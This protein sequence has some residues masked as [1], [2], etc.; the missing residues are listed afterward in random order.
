VQNLEGGTRVYQ[1]LPETEKSCEHLKAARPWFCFPL[2]M[3][4]VLDFYFAT[5]RRLMGGVGLSEDPSGPFL[6]NT[7]GSALLK[8]RMT[9][10]F[11][12]FLYDSTGC[13]TSLRDYRLGFSAAIMESELPMSTIRFVVQQLRHT[14]ATA[15][16]YY[17]Q[18]V[19]S[20]PA[21]RPLDV[22]G[23]LLPV[24]LSEKIV[25]QN[26]LQVLE[27][28]IEHHRDVIDK[29][30]ETLA[31]EELRYRENVHARLP[32]KLLEL[33]EVVDDALLTSHPRSLSLLS[34][35]PP[36]DTRPVDAPLV[37]PQLPSPEL[38]LSPVVAPLKQ[39][40]TLS[41]SGEDDE[42]Q[43]LEHTTLELL[44]NPLFGGGCMVV[45]CGGNGNCGPLVVA[46][47]LSLVCSQDITAE[48]VREAVALALGEPS[49][50]GRY[51]EDR[52]DRCSCWAV[53]GQDHRPAI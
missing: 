8:D 46:A 28:A 32:E 7:E 33:P 21:P 53:S 25:G 37:T 14:Y 34:P 30:I 3:T 36:L 40:V 51:W 44:Q 50:P 43:R 52:G 4:P 29:C 22:T 26:L 49:V 15:E 17:L 5:G 11:Q 10:W 12:K 13:Q 35:V 39:R 41:S 18:R 31:Q 1:L 47:G 38:A 48:E 19:K 6:L 24:P 2:E 42:H 27:E 23:W 16:T 9:L 45:D 20:S